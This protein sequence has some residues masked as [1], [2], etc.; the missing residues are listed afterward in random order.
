MYFASHSAIAPFHLHEPTSS[1]E[2]VGLLECLP[3]V[4]LLAGGVDL[5]PALRAG[6]RTDNLVSLAKANDLKALEAD[7]SGLRVGGGVTLD[8]LAR[9]A[10][11][12]AQAPDLARAARD[13]A[14]IRVRCAATLGGN[15]AAANPGY[16]LLPLLIAAGAEIR[17][18]AGARDSQWSFDGGPVGWAPAGVISG[19]RVPVRNR[20]RLRA[21]RRYKPVAS[22]FTGLWQ[23]AEGLEGVVAVG[24]AY[25]QIWMARLPAG[26]ANPAQLVTDAG[27][28]AQRMTIDLPTPPD[29]TVAGGAYR[30]RLIRAVLRQQLESMAT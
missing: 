7:T 8:Q 26:T 4:A 15:L 25:D 23:T 27:D 11:L 17:V 3:E 9:W 21:E 5:I 13:I 16:D 20:Q 19:I 28:L 10:P 14:N 30:T 22:V 2:A 12:E 6:R 1:A 24:C 18:N 29:S